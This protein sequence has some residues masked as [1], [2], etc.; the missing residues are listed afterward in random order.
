MGFTGDGQWGQAAYCLPSKL[1]NFQTF[2]AGAAGGAG[3]CFCCTGGGAVVLAGSCG[4]AGQ[5]PLWA[6]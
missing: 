6:D 4:G 5:F 3:A 1:L 2:D